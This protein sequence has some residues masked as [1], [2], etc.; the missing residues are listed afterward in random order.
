MML[1]AASRNIPQAIAA[2]ACIG[3]CI[4]A[5]LVVM[6]TT[7]QQLVPPEFLGR[8]TSLEIFGSLILLPPAYILIGMLITIDGPRAA[9][10]V[11]GIGLILLALLALCFRS[12][13][14]VQ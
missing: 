13:R 11:S 7:V 3:A 4:A 2:G 6:E 8:V 12:V 9:I 5:F 1:L 14:M 10:L